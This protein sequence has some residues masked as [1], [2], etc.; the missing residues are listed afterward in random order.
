[1]D[2]DD[3]YQELMALLNKAEQIMTDLFADYKR[4]ILELQAVCETVKRAREAQRRYFRTRGSPELAEARAWEDQ[5]DRLV[6]EMLAGEDSQG[7]AQ[8]S[9]GLD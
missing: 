5:L 2:G 7:S 4:A 3:L 8:Q 9:L 1:M 6:E